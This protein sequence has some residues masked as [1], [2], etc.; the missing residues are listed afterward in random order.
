M[1]DIIQ[2]INKDGTVLEVFKNAIIRYSDGFTI[3]CGRYNEDFYRIPNGNVSHII[4]GCEIV[5]K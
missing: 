5:L 2:V 4:K 3:I 1:K